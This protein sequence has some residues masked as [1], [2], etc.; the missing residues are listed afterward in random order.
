MDPKKIFTLLLL[1]AGE[2][3]II[4]CF[5]YFGRNLDT[6][7]L[8]LN[9]IVTT[10]IYAL[11]NIDI[12][13]PMV[14][15]KDKSQRIIGSLGIRWFF[16]ILYSLFAIGAMVFFNKDKPIDFN[17]QIII[18]GILFFLLL[19]GFLLAFSASAK[20]NEVYVEET[21][22]RSHLEDMKKATKEVI[23]KLDKLKD[24]PVDVIIRTSALFE[25]LRFISPSNN[26]E[27]SDLESNYLKEIKEVHDC[28]FVIPL[29]HEKIIENIQ[30]CERTYK[31]RKQIYS[32]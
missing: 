17:I 5:L 31:E 6:N 24:T 29:N 15:F 14:D 2:V 32:T 19:L 9:I 8:T 28:L 3:L 10:I 20:V 7:I 25:N 18:Q 13:F 12:L 11:F 27:A 4:I 23:L 30:N 22:N 1:A 26:Q 16:T 21:I